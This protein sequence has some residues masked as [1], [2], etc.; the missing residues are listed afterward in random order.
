VSQAVA[1][2]PLPANLRRPSLGGDVLAFVVPVILF[3]EVEF[4]GRLFVS[5]LLLLACLPVLLAVR[6]NALSAKFPRTLLALGGAWLLAQ[7]ASDMVNATLF[8]D[9]ARGWAKIAF[10]LSNFTALYLLIG[11]DRRRIVLFVTGWAIGGILKY[12]LLPSGYA[13]GDPWKFG[14]GTGVTILVLL[15]ALSRP[16]SAYR[17]LSTLML[18]GLAALNLV[19]GSR[20]LAGLCFLTA[21]Y[22]PIQGFLHRR[23]GTDTRLSFW[24]LG[25][26][27]VMALALS[28]A[29][30]EFYAYAAE[31]GYLGDTARTTYERQAGAFGVLLGGRAE[32][33]VSTRAIMDAPVLGHGS[34]AKGPD[35]AVML[36]QLADYGYHVGTEVLGWD[37]IPTHSHF[38][39]AWVEA[40]IVG[41]I[42]WGWTLSLAVRVLAGLHAVRSRL[43]P[44]IAFFGFM[45]VWDVLFSPF[46]AERRFFMPFCIVLFMATLGWLEEKARHRPGPDG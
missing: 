45:F 23:G 6:G 22:L 17:V 15:L 25:G 26:L 13:V 36:L 28:M 32:I 42:F 35:Y 2:P 44:M 40:G 29:F 4:I 43:A 19:L 34:W 27:L 8:E 39:G 41:A 38:F 33:F 21:A 37:R 11:G 46:G 9:Y 14:I 30:I 24:R 1:S 7:V 10:T 12:L 3:L 16:L 31:Q 20:S 18:G 5:E